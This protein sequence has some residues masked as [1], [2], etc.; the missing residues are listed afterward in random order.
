MRLLTDCRLTVRGAL[1]KLTFLVKMVKKPLYF[2]IFFL[3]VIDP[4]VETFFFFFFS[5]FFLSLNL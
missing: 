4:P 1:V 5:F 3:A 2:C